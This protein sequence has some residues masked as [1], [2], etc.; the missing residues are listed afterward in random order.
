V[1]LGVVPNL[2]KMLF[3]AVLVLDVVALNVAVLRLL[4][5]P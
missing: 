5:R 4:K 2:A 1:D 3:F